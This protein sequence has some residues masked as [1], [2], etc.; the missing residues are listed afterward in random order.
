MLYL[1]ASSFRG[2]AI[3]VSESVFITAKTSQII[4]PFLVQA[5]NKILSV[6][7]FLFFHEYTFQIIH[8]IVFLIV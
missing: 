8:V 6:F 3:S 2:V 5:N 4:N 7:A 1:F